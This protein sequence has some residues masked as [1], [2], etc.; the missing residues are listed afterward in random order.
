LSNKTS[1]SV[2]IALLALLSACGKSS[3]KKTNSIGTDNTPIAESNS[4]PKVSTKENVPKENS[5][6]EV[7]IEAAKLEKLKNSS[8]LEFGNVEIANRRFV[9]VQIYGYGREKSNIAYFEIPS[10]RK[11]SSGR[12]LLRTAD[13]I[14]FRLPISVGEKANKNF[15]V[16]YGMTLNQNI[17]G[18]LCMFGS[19]GFKGMNVGTNANELKNIF[20]LQMVNPISEEFTFGKT[21]V[22]FTAN[23]HD[24]GSPSTGVVSG[25]FYTFGSYNGSE[26]GI[27]QQ[28]N[29]EVEMMPE[30]LFEDVSIQVEK[31]QSGNFGLVRFVNKSQHELLP[32][33]VDAKVECL[34]GGG[35]ETVFMP[36]Y[37]SGYKPGNTVR[38]K[39]SPLA[40]GASLEFNEFDLRNAVKTHLK[41]ENCVSRK[42]LLRGFDIRETNG[43][44]PFPSYGMLVPEN[45]IFEF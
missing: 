36:R 23:Y 44:A 20:D 38:Y 25:T 18:A 41:L 27:T 39:I 37:F 32:L 9:D 13:P 15:T 35:L 6:S 24:C 33:E 45:T 22:E 40:V 8:T 5:Q 3:K 29:F 19:L 42:A 34:E 2:S 1:L 14:S 12:T 21:L 11:S 10:S 16:N 31:N 17:S 4:T 26:A 30:T 7:E 28:S 43:W